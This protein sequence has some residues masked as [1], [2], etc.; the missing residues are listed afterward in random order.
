MTPTP[1][2]LKRP[3]CSA[4]VDDQP[5]GVGGQHRRGACGR[6]RSRV[7]VEGAFDIHEELP[8]KQ[9]VI[10]ASRVPPERLGQ[11]EGR[12]STVRQSL[13]VLQKREFT[14][15]NDIDLGWIG[16][17][18]GSL[19]KFVVELLGKELDASGN[20]RLLVCNVIAEKEASKLRWMGT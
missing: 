14:P 20:I 1:V 18:R 16:E 8:G 17:R 7:T 2:I 9:D 19:G 11:F 15:G 10:N 6:P 4:G 13:N 3:A 12:T 5:V